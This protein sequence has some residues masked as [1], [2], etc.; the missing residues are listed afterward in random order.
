MSDKYEPS[1]PCQ[2]GEG[3]CT[4]TECNPFHEAVTNHVPTAWRVPEEAMSD[5][6]ELKACPFCGATWEHDDQYDA[7][8]IWHEDW[9]ILH[10]HTIYDDDHKAIKAWNTRAEPEWVS[11]EDRLPESAVDVWTYTKADGAKPIKGYYHRS[12]GHWVVASWVVW[13]V[14]H[15]CEIKEPAPPESEAEGE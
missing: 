12:M 2:K 11:V 14:T 3:H 13:T 15:W 9:C 8:L 1:W 7:S 4:H 6:V 10:L 5:K